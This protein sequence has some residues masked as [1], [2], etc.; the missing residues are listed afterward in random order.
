[1]TAGDVSVHGGR[2][3]FVRR[4]VADLALGVR[5][6]AG[7]GRASWTR[8]VLTAVGVGLGV[9]LLL[10]AC[11][12]PAVWRAHQDR[13][14]SRSY[15]V[16]QQ[17]GP[18]AG[19]DRTVLVASLDTDY[20]DT[21]VHG[22]A[23]QA[24]GAHPALPP[25]TGALPGPGEMLVSPALRALLSSSDGA[26]LRPRLPYRIV[27]TIGSAGLAGPN[28][29]AFYAG[30]DQLAGRLADGSVERV[31]RFGAPVDHHA[32]DPVLLLLTVVAVAVLLVPIAVF[33]GSAVRFGAESRDR[34]QAALRLVGADRSMTRR[35][36]AG[37]ALVG[38]LLGLVVGGAL[39]LLGRQLI[40]LVTLED[41]SVFASDVRPDPVLVALIAVL[42]PVSAVAVSVLALR[43]V[44]VEPL[45]VVRQATAVKRRLW[46]RLI[47]PA[48]GIGLLVPLLGGVRA[49]GER[50][51]TLQVGAAVA[52]LLI[53]VAVLLPWLVEAVVRRLGG[54]GVAWQ[55]AIRRLQL[56]SGSAAR[57]VSGIAVAVAGAVGLLTLFAGVQHAYQQPTHQDPSRAQVDVNVP[58]PLSLP[59]AREL[60][61]RFAAT[62]GVRS[63]FGVSSTTIG[64]TEIGSDG[65][66]TQW[67]LVVGDCA[68]LR[69]LASIDRCADGDTFL[70]TTS[71]EGDEQAPPAG[72][73]AAML[74]GND[75]HVTGTWTVPG[76]ARPVRSRPTPDA[77]IQ[78]GVFATPSAVNAQLLGQLR[79]TVYVGVDPSRPDTLDRVRNVAAA[80]DPLATV[81]QL[82]STR[83]D[84]TL[85]TIERGI[86]AGATAVLLLIGASL[87]VTVLEQLRERRRLLA[88]LVAFGTRRGTLT[89]SVLWQT[90][91]PVFLGLLLAVAGGLVLGGLLLRLTSEPLSF[92][93]AQI[94]G[95]AGI[96]AAVVLLVTVLSMP[97]LWRLMRP[98]GMRTE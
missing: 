77:S 32:M 54:G 97:A 42:V 31:D 20:R 5:L 4:W 51:S 91:V 65:Y 33:I 36:A 79:E 57:V 53:G 71:G 18:V 43:R 76:T 11:S 93:W 44:V 38:A 80:T 58:R 56:S 2:R 67:S 89:A 59:Q 63:V 41:L 45:G 22:L 78:A 10:L 47:L 86:F 15:D 8:L 82:S 34:Q 94:A 70:A 3:G 72:T 35:I 14:A 95:I 27:G 29:V 60:A 52:L 17:D 98:E 9:A 75:E 62:P 13:S 28:E 55:L 37:E 1:M 12:A 46:W 39:F 61:G 23:L 85:V 25:G 84:S 88:V 21:P 48:V 96:G 6:V 74:A 50:F 81:L 49:G 19:G 24:D 73:R 66:R 30:S 90:A 16:V 87:L 83:T 69:Q 7:G 26:L 92:A 40:E 64:D 68:T